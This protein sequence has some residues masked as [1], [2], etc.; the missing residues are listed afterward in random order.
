M[1]CIIFAKNIEY[2][3][4]DILIWVIKNCGLILISLFIVG[5]LV[6]AFF[7]DTDWFLGLPNPNKRKPKRNNRF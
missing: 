1:E 4:W 5:L 2:M 6:F 7:L 3:Y